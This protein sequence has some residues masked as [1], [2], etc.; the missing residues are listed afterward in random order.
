MLDIVTPVSF[1]HGIIPRLVVMF[2]NF[3]NEIYSFLCMWRTFKKCVKID[4]FLCHT[5][6]CLK[7]SRTSH[8]SVKK[9]FVPEDA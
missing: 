9:L 5:A 6:L 7:S 8:L 2:G 4:S 3:L 1:W